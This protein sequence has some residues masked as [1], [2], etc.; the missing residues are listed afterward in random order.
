MLF[1]NRLEIWNPGTLPQELSI[2][3]L[4]L[5]HTSIPGNPLIANPLFLTGDIERVGTGISD[6]IDKCIAMGLRKPVFTQDEGF[7]VTLWRHIETE[8]D[9]GEQIGEQIGGQISGQIGGQIN[10][11]LTD[12]QKE[13]LDILDNNPRITRSQ[14]SQKLQIN[15]SAIYKHLDKLKTKGLI[16]RIGPDKGGYWKVKTNNK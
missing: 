11:T 9:I 16:E 3:K 14:L 10:D 4:Y 15:K 13:I 2:E 5:P 7:K 6:M 12:R 1:R 8:S